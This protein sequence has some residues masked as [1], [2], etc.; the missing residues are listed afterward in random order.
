M[1]NKL[2]KA[3]LWGPELWGHSMVALWRTIKDGK[4]ISMTAYEFDDLPATI[5]KVPCAL[6]IITQ[7]VGIE[8]S[9]GGMNSALWKGQTEF[10]LTGNLDKSGLSYLNQFYRLIMTAA[11]SHLYLDGD[12][13]FSILSTNSLDPAVLQW[14][15]DESSQHYGIICNWQVFENLGNKISLEL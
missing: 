5:E 10:H 1:G 4:G 2:T 12:A 3:D 7:P 6:S 11:T 8:Y 15:G 14:G 13:E 9:Q